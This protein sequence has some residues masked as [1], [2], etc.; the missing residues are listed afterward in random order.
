MDP[1]STLAQLF[2]A[3]MRAG[4]VRWIG[5]R[6]ARGVDVVAVEAA[7]LM[8][9]RGIDGDRYRSSSDGARQVTIIEAESLAAVASYLGR[10][11][12]APALLRRNIVVAGINLL[13]LKGRRFRLGAALLE[14]SGECHPCSKMEAALGPGGYNA[15]RGRGGI[16]ARVLEG[17]VVRLGDAIAAL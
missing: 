15:M 8:Q 13:A 9:A 11:E 10:N 6:H 16:T 17:G 14:Y 2:A 3:P 5:L 7:M 12:V 1:A 4:R